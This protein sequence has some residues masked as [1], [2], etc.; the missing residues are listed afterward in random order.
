MFGHT[1]N[2]VHRGCI[3]AVIII[4]QYGHLQEQHCISGRNPRLTDGN[5]IQTECTLLCQTAKCGVYNA[6]NIWNLLLLLIAQCVLYQI[7]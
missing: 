5:K 6:E 3:T 4:I 1:P 2:S 7:W